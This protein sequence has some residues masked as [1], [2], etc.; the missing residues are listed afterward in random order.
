MYKSRA[1]IIPYHFYGALSISPRC[2][3]WKKRCV[4]ASSNRF[5]YACCKQIINNGVK[6]TSKLTH[7]TFSVM[8]NRL[9]LFQSFSI[10]LTLVE[11]RTRRPGKSISA[12]Y[13][14]LSVA[15]R[16]CENVTFY[17]K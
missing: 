1:L 10:S 12:T 5:E 14:M 6:T 7:E 3:V 11:T 13:I 8:M 9:I 4:A 16:V 2:V 17:S 15:V